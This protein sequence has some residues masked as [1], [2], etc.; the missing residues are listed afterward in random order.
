MLKPLKLAGVKTCRHNALITRIIQGQL[1]FEMRVSNQSGPQIRLMFS[2]AHRSVFRLGTFLLIKNETCTFK[3]TQ[4][5]VFTQ[6]KQTEATPRKNH[7][8]KICLHARICC[9]GVRSAH[10][11][12]NPVYAVS[13]GEINRA[14]CVQDIIINQQSPYRYNVDILINQ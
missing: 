13:R 1:Q 9:S 8:T 2:H 10:S 7:D 11:K 12:Q 3:L 4:G 5:C 14:V 6:T